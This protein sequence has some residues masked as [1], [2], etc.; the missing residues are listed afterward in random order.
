MWC[1]VIRLVVWYVVSRRLV[2]WYGAVWI[3]RGSGFVLGAILG[4]VVAGSA[5][6]FYLRHRKR[7]I[8]YLHREKSTQPPPH[9]GT[10]G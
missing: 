7:R 3:S 9:T 8:E 1:D 5:S 6:Y 2:L 4:A 10:D